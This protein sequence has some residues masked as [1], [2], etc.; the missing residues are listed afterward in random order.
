MS[1][2]AAGQ[3]VPIADLAVHELYLRQHPESDGSELGGKRF[4]VRC[5]R[6]DRDDRLRDLDPTD[7]NKLV[8]IKGMVTR[9]SSVV[10]DLYM[11]FFECSVC[12]TPQEVFILRGEIQEPQAPRRPART[13]G[14]AAAT[15]GATRCC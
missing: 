1:F 13:A 4:T 8:S 9:T 2:A 12:K 15:T 6:L 10:P 11:A 3:V 7:I 14:H 5:F